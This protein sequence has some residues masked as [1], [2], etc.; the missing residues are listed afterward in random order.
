[1]G[2]LSS[3]VVDNKII[4]LNLQF[5]NK[6]T[7]SFDSTLEKYKQIVN[8]DGV[9]SVNIDINK[10]GE[11]VNNKISNIEGSRNIIEK[12]IENFGGII[13]GNKNTTVDNTFVIKNSYDNKYLK[14]YSQTG[15]T[16]GW[17][18]TSTKMTHNIL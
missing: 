18:T 17:T 11:F 6:D 7:K 3:K 9:Y 16:P 13:I 5:A 1:M 4:E 14:N 8:N 15:K 10:F 12:F 2:G